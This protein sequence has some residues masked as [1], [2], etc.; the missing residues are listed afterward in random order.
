MGQF[1]LPWCLDISWVGLWWLGMA[2]RRLAYLVGCCACLG[3]VMVKKEEVVLALG[4]WWWL[5]LP[6]EPLVA[7]QRASSLRP[8]AASSALSQCRRPQ[9][10]VHHAAFCARN[11]CGCAQGRLIYTNGCGFWTAKG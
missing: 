5:A 4:S 11:V 7:R 10:L 8:K 9:S 2:C 1:L 6:N 3:D